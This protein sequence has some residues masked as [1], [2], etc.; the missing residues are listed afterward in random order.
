M[1][2]TMP[3]GIPE[4]CLDKLI[5]DTVSKEGTNETGFSRSGAEFNLTCPAQLMRL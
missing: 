4:Q 5:I 3:P 1:Q 2:N